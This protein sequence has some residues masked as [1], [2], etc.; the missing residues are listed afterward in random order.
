MSTLRVLCCDHPQRT[1]ALTTNEYALIFRNTPTPA[2]S[3]GS[4]AHQSIDTP[5]CIVEF[6]SLS[7]V[8]LGDYRHLA[9][10]HGT[11]GLITLNN[12]VFLCVVTASSRAATVRPG[13]TVLRIDNVEF[14]MLSFF[15]Y[16]IT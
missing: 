15:L 6:S 4:T 14:C 16:L 12:D 1:I 13:E 8:D 2:E 3:Q 7:S 10:G 5:R 11:L 9:D